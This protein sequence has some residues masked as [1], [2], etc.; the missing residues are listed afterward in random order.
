MN[1]AIIY[2][3]S[4]GV[5]VISV[6]APVAPVYAQSSAATSTTTNQES[7]AKDI[8]IPIT[9]HGKG[10]QGSEKQLTT[11]TVKNGEYTVRVETMNQQSV[12]P[13]SDIVVRS[14]DSKVVV[15]DVESASFVEKTAE[16]TLTVSNGTV[17]VYVVFGVDKVFSGGVKVVLTEVKPT[18][19]EQPKEAEKPEA[20]PEA[21]EEPVV[22]AEEKPE[23]EETAGK[24]AGEETPEELPQTGPAAFLSGVAG[25]S[26]LGLGAHSWLNSRKAVRKAIK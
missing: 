26:A 14:G 4:A 10:D 20:K 16:G 17:N 11:K 9:T 5:A 24:G 12:H 2:I 25:A 3:A 1:K 22:E 7:E 19:A 15:N 8:E 21:E 13:N 18:E 23:T 6:V